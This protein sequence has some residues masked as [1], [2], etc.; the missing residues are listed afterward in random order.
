VVQSRDVAMTT[1]SGNDN[2]VCSTWLVDYENAYLVQVFRD[3][4]EYPDL[5]RKVISL[6]LEHNAKTILIEVRG[7]G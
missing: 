6:A 4:L 3:R 7:R 1:S 5:H 2:S